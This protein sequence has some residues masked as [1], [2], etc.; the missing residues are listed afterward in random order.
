MSDVY[1]TNELT[2]VEAVASTGPNAEVAVQGIQGPPGPP[3]V[4]TPIYGQVWTQTPQPVL[5]GTQGVYQSTGVTAALDPDFLGVGLGLVD[6]FAVRNTLATTHRVT[7]IATYDAFTSGPAAT[8]GLVLSLNGTVVPETECRATT[9]ASGALAKL[10]TAWLFDLA[11]GDEVA[12][13]VANHSSTATIEFQRGRIVASGV[14]GYGPQG[15][16]GPGVPTGGAAGYTLVK[17]AAADYATGWTW[18][19]GMAAPGDWFGIVGNSSISVSAGVYGTPLFVAE[20]RTIDRV[21]IRV[22]SGSAGVLARVGIYSVDSLWTGSLL[23]DTGS[24]IDCSTSGY[25]EAL[26][27]AAQLPTG[28]VFVCVFYTGVLSVNAVEPSTNHPLVAA[29]SNVGAASSAM[30]GSTSWSTGALPGTVTLNS[31]W[32]RMPSVVFY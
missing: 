23:I 16:T 13:L 8:L 6:G 29:Y 5:I 11:P 2:I 32:R 28:W 12:L 14:S 3:G 18:S 20:S 27:G 17:T 1:V 15:P 19:P 25:K 4:G 21:R 9:S 10:H 22:A 30:S 7:I 26:F 31:V 24:D